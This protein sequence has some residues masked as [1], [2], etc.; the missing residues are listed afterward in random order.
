MTQREPLPVA[1]LGG[2]VKLGGAK[3]VFTCLISELN[4]S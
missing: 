1:D 2:A 4:G 3:N